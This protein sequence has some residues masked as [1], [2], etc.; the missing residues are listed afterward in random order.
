MLMP[1][2]ILLLLV[3]IAALA[4]PLIPQ[5]RRQT[6]LAGFPAV[7]LALLFANAIFFAAT[8]GHDGDIK[9]SVAAAWGMTPR[10]ASIVT[11]LTHMFLHGDFSHIFFNMLG[12][13][14][15]GP[16]VEEALGKIEYLLFYLGGGIA[17]GILHLLIAGTLLPAAASVPLIGASGAIFG[18]LGLFAVRFW[19]ASVRVFLFFTVPAAWAVGIFFL[20]QFGQAILSL[21]DGGEGSRIANWAHVGGFVFGALIAFPLRM[22]EESK[23]E[24]DLEDAEK[25]AATGDLDRAAAF[26][27]AAL[28]AKPDDAAAHHS[29]ARVSMQLR[30]AEEAHRHLSDSLHLYLQQNNA[31]GVARVYEDMVRGFDNF[32]LPP[33]LLQRV[34]SA[35]E[36]AEHYS[37]SV[38]AL[39]DLCRTNPGTRVEEMALLRLGKLYLHKT[40][41]PWEAAGV[42]AEFLRLYPNSEW[43]SHALRLRDEAEQSASSSQGP[44]G[45]SR[46]AP[47][48]PRAAG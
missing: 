46:H 24:Y 1:L 34:A 22:R 31:P 15:F 25:A 4:A 6:G 36:E 21:G 37:L 47:S 41:Q 10:A 43:A 39:S 20:L 33:H 40:A 14:L 11:L 29:I 8:V 30:R 27:R 17:A 16:H 9:A 48:P 44:R 2:G 38:H 19:R 45:A 18:I 32:P 23:R 5:R 3:M 42:F 28:A 35:C 12:L 13:W 26:Y 7:T